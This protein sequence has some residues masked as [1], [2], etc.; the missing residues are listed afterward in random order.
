[1]K[2]NDLPDYAKKY[3]VKGYD[4]KKVGNEYYQ[5]K[6]EHHRQK[7]KK[8]PVTRFVYIGKIDK[9]KGLILA[10]SSDYEA[11]DCYLEF[12]LSNYLFKYYKR[13][14]QRSLFNCSGDY[15][16][17][18]IKLGIIQYIFNDVS[19]VTLSSSYLTFKEC[20]SLFSFYNDNEQNKIKV[21]KVANKISSCLNS[22]FID[23]EERSTIINSL[24]NMNACISKD[25]E[26]INKVVPLNAK[27]I[28]ERLGVNYE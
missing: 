19:K 23:E 4:V 3:K 12:G 27:V 24:R 25:K 5:Y 14:L 6:V 15:G 7:D 28:F 26:R 20:D 11:V 10:N 18:L 16:I 22:I 21:L 1:M 8:Y 13:A 9:D 17:N 2:I